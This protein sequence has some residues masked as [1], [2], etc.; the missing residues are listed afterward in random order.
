[1]NL[2]LLLKKWCKHLETIEL[3]NKHPRVKILK[4]RPGVGGPLLNQGS[5]FLAENTTNSP[6][7]RDGQGN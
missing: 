2:P 1:M 4:S 6:D 7:N 5:L 3:A